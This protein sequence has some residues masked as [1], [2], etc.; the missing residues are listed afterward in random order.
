MSNAGSNPVLTT[1]SKRYSE[2]FNPRLFN[3]GLGNELDILKA[4]SLGERQVVV[5]PSKLD[6]FVWVR[7]SSF[8]KG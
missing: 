6:F 4:N 1:M 7:P 8:L 2:V 5:S 3:N